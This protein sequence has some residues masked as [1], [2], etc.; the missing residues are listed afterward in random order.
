MCLPFGSQLPSS[1]IEIE[2]NLN[3]A[4]V[5]MKLRNGRDLEK[6]LIRNASHRI[7]G[8]IHPFNFIR[9][10]SLSKKLLLGVKKSK[11]IINSSIVISIK[12]SE[13]FY[14]SSIAYLLV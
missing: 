12:I 13:Y 14:S 5:E 6:K 2:E 9:S 11:V 8:K 3:G 7:K 4:K 1:L 10:I